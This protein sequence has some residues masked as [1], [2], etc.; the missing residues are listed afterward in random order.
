[1]QKLFNISKTDLP[2]SD[3]FKTNKSKVHQKIN[4]K[5]VFLNLDIQF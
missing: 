5:N 1:M 3:Y 2:K 4:D